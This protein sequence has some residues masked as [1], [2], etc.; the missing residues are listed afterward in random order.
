[1]HA[2]LIA[3]GAELLLGEIVDTNSAHIAR[4][5][6]EVGVEVRWV[7]TV[8]DHAARIIPR[9][10]ARALGPDHRPL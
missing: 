4:A 10:P 5:L 7:S 2:E 9:I 3:I 6:R 1:M 8:G